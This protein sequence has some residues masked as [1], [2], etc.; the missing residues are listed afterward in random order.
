MNYN[1][2]ITYCDR[3]SRWQCPWSLACFKVRVLDLR[4]RCINSKVWWTK[5]IRNR[6]H[7]FCPGAWRFAGIIYKGNYMFQGA[8]MGQPFWFSGAYFASH[9]TLSFTWA[10]DKSCSSPKAIKSSWG[11]HRLSVFGNPTWVWGAGALD[12]LDWAT[13]T[14]VS[15]HVC[16]ASGE[17]FCQCS[18][19]TL[20][21]GSHSR[22]SGERYLFTFGFA[23]LSV[24]AFCFQVKIGFQQLGRKPPDTTVFLLTCFALLAHA[25]LLYSARKRTWDSE[26]YYISKCIESETN[27]TYTWFFFLLAETKVANMGFHHGFWASVGI[28]W[29]IGWG[30]GGRYFEY[31]KNCNV[32]SCLLF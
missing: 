8:N 31:V 2:S 30:I 14:G 28:G 5:S 10:S 4:G 7:I 26:T 19:A 23:W 22:R 6:H 25:E 12:E 11:G 24:V 20:C 27:H 15:I 9:I 17:S 18:F 32:P 1:E 21:S 13:A 16:W 29:G 3:I